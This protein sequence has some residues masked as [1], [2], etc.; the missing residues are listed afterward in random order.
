MPRLLSLII[1][2]LLSGVVASADVYKWVDSD[3]TV[4]YSDQPPPGAVKEQSLSNKSGTPPGSS[5]AS[6]AGNAAPNAAGPKTYIEQDAEFRKRQVE[7]E[8][9]HAKEEKVLAEAKGRQ[10]NCE[11]ARSSLQS[12]QSGQRVVKYN[13]KGERVYLDD[14]ER[15][16]E[17]ANAQKSVD[18][19]CNP[20]K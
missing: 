10:Q 18:S 12:L 4:H 3:G 15:G 14:N 16:Q 6:G 17:I 2:S 7:A 9:K 1:L 11:H 8:E 13:E 5:G 20:R 19:W